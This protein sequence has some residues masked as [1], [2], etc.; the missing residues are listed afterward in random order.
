[1]SA[2]FVGIVY[3]FKTTMKANMKLKTWPSVGCFY[4]ERQSLLIDITMSAEARK[5]A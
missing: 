5:F 3:Y 4:L 1:M 2:D